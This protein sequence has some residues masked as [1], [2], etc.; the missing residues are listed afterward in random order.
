MLGKPEEP[1]GGTLWLHIGNLWLHT[2]VV[3]IFRAW[4]YSWYHC[5][6]AQ[7]NCAGDQDSKVSYHW[8]PEPFRF[9]ASYLYV[10]CNRINLKV[11]KSARTMRFVA[12][13]S[14][15]LWKW[16][17]QHWPSW[18]FQ[19]LQLCV[20][21]WDALFANNAFCMLRIFCSFPTIRFYFVF[22]MEWHCCFWK[23]NGY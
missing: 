12:K 22:S 2:V 17:C 6:C 10:L 5:Q 3:S 16:T 9:F 21:Y 18:I 14:Q 23:R 13:L 8:W 20:V 19:K 7:V 1:M 11:G 4:N 15:T